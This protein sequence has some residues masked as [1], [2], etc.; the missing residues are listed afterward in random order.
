MAKLSNGLLVLTAGRPGIWL[1]ITSDP[2]ARWTPWDLTKHHNENYPDAAHHYNLTTFENDYGKPH[3]P[4]LQTTSYTGMAVVPGGNQI[5][6][7]YDWLNAFKCPHTICAHA[8]AV[9]TVRLSVESLK[10]DDKEACT[11][12]TSL[13]LHPDAIN[14]SMCPGASAFGPY[15]GAILVRVPGQ[16]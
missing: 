14:H 1:W 12:S 4:V 9:F 16:C 13:L 10:S 8:S 2:P 6:L 3:T 7:S 5:V 15:C 11:P